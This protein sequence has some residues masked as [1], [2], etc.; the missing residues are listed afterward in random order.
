MDQEWTERDLRIDRGRERE[1]RLSF[2]ED[3][4]D[5]VRERE[6]VMLELS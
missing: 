4:A 6:R 5:L 2:H 1:L 3:C